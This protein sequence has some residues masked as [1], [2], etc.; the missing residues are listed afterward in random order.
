[1]VSTAGRAWFALV[2]L[3]ALYPLSIQYYGGQLT[4][5][6][7]HSL[8]VLAMIYVMDDRWL[9]LA[10]ALALGILAKETVMILVPAYY[11]CHR[12]KGWP[13]LAKTCMLAFACVAAWTAARL[14]LGWKPQMDSINGTSGL[15]IGSNLGFSAPHYH[16]AAPLYEN[17]LR[18]LIFVGAWLPFIWWG[19]PAMD[20]R[21]KI[22]F[23]VVTPLLLAT[24]LCF[25]W[26]YESRNYMP[27]VPLLAA[28]ASW[29]WITRAKQDVASQPRVSVLLESMT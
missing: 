21:L 9:A 13:V 17:Y 10:A 2:A 28:M 15:M 23:L 6:L 22:L 24:N 20:R 26:M 16:G 27:L 14:P 8:F 19:W 12:S 5:P 29:P 3:A 18:P 25:G 4:D 1:M 11:F 7:S